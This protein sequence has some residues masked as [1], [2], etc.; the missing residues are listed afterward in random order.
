MCGKVEVMLTYSESSA[1][2][3]LYNESTSSS[4][5]VNS[6]GSTTESTTESKEIFKDGTNEAVVEKQITPTLEGAIIIAE[7]ARR[8]DD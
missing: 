1:I 5:S 6:D 2:S 7:G 4:K 3:P 8:C